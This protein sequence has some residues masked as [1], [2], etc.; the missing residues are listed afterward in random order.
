MSNLL[1]R[2]KEYPE[3][4]P[5]GFSYE[6]WLEN[7]I[8]IQDGADYG[9]FEK[10]IPGVVLGHYLFESRGKAAIEAGKR[11]LSAVFTLP[12]FAVIGVIPE[13]NKRVSYISRKLGFTIHDDVAILTKDEWNG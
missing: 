6:D 10:D 7:T 11:I 9:L 8:V 1:D 5:E 4:I 3:M 2:L 13:G 12:V